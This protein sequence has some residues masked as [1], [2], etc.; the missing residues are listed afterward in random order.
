MESGTLDTDEL[1]NTLL[2]A[3]LT[4]HYSYFERRLE[5]AVNPRDDKV[6]REIATAALDLFLRTCAPAVAPV[7]EERRAELVAAM[8]AERRAIN[9]VLFEMTRRL[10][11]PLFT[12]PVNTIFN[13][14]RR[15]NLIIAAD[16]A[17][18][19]GQYAQVAKE[20]F[21]AEAQFAD[22]RGRSWADFDGRNA[23]VYGTA[24]SPLVAEVLEQARWQVTD[25]YVALGD[26]KFEG[27][28]L[29]L[30][31][32]RARPTDTTLGDVIYTSADERILVGINL[33]HHG[34]SDFVIGRLT[35]TGRYQIV[36][37]GNFA[38]SED[39]QLLTTLPA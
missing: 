9:D 38:R 11:R 5:A 28:Q 37:R 39:G 19:A 29:A 17:S 15:I 32:C 6:S 10:E 34:P 26:R 2:L 35:K 27:E 7:V 31:A 1:V 14:L 25:S 24:S 36:T 16:A 3:T 8:I 33:L 30:I 4:H 20:Q 21:L 13:S 18:A 22:A 23:I 12:G